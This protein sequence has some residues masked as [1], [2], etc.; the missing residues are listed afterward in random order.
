MTAQPIWFLD[1]L[2]RV[3][4]DG[5]ATDG[6]YALVEC[7]AP[8]GHM[9]PPHVHATDAEG[10]LVLEGELSVHT[11]EGTRVL[12]PG[13]AFNAP[14]GEPHTIEV[15]SDGPAR[16]TVVSSPAGFER[17]VRALGRPAEREELPVLEGPPD[18]DRLVAVAAE[19]GITFV[20]PPGTRPEVLAAA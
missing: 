6:E 18:V 4:I 1:T 9:P 14:A 7:L 11:A 13:M 12:G 17:F 16:W 8:P 3:H 2:V 15:T 10:F 5:A 20:G 19:H